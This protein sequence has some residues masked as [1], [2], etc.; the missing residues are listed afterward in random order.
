MVLVQK[1]NML[2]T[3]E[4]LPLDSCQDVREIYNEL[5]L[6]EVTQE[7]PGDIPD[8]KLFRKGPVSIYSPSQKEIHKGLYPE[9]RILQAMEQA[10][11]FLGDDSCEILF[12]ISIFPLFIGVYS[13]IL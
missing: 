3:K 4:E 11:R 7:E 12:R 13:S 5:V 6:A 2:M 10:L 8:G 1:Y 9:E